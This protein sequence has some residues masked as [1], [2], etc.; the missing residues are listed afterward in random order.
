M[1][2]RDEIGREVFGTYAL[3]SLT[4]GGGFRGCFWKRLAMM[5]L[6]IMVV[7]LMLNFEFGPVTGVMG[8]MEGQET[9]FRKPKVAFVS[10]KS[11]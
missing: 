2:Y 11:L 8:G 7:T 5:E 10:L 4:F 3:P 1:L 6:Y 9:V